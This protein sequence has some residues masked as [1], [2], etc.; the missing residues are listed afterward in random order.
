MNICL[1]KSPHTPRDLDL[2]FGSEPVHM[3]D[4]ED[5]QSLM[6]ECKIY[7]SK[8]QSIKAGRHGPIPQGWTVLRASRKVT[9]WIW[10]PSE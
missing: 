2:L 6:L 1:R 9:L 10:N 3:S 4:A 5:L 8:S 7:K